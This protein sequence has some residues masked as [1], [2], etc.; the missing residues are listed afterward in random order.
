MLPILVTLQ[1][2][3]DAK[4][5]IVDRLTREE[6]GATAVEYGLIVG[7]MAVIVVAAFVILGPKINSLFN[8]LDF[9]T[10]KT[11]AE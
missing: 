10:A 4:N 11:A 5:S 6:K 8:G 1:Y 9:G 7:L 2:V 3:A